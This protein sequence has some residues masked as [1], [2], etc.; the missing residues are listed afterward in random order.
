MACWGWKVQRLREALSAR[1][2]L[3]ST[4]ARPRRARPRDRRA[5]S[6]S[7]HASIA[8]AAGNTGRGR[9]REGFVGLRASQ[10]PNRTSR[11]GVRD[12][13]GGGEGVRARANSA[14]AEAADS[15]C[16]RGHVGVAPSSPSQDW[17]G[18]AAL[19]RGGGVRQGGELEP[20]SSASD[21]HTL[22]R[23]RHP[24]PLP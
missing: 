23:L 20:R 2:G 4:D 14:V 7:R 5:R 22:R 1:P 10:S 8:H 12:G 9:R 15:V 17:A 18:R 6:R 21:T 11:V 16:S 19:C 13:G 3:D 24:V